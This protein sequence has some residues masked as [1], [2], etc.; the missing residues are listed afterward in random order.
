M[1]LLDLTDINASYG[2][3][4][5]L[6]GVDLTLSAGETLA[7]AGANG[8]GK[9]TLMRLLCGLMIPSRG[10]VRIDG[11][12][13]PHGNPRAAA[14]AGLALVPEGRL[15]FDSLTVEENLMIGAG[16]RQGR[17]SLSALYD[18]FPILR[19]KRQQSPGSL[20]GGQQQM[21]AIGRALAANPRILLC[22][23]ISLGLSP[24]VTG[25]VYN[26]LKLV[27]AEGIA[28]VVVDQ[29]VARA[30]AI[31]NRVACMFQGRV[32]L[33]RPAAAVDAASISAA[34]FGETA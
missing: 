16:A 15:L 29:D 10:A 17:W 33:D 3:M 30:Q 20:S 6:H 24:L 32:T 18:L 22:D 23:E 7:L 2:Q 25:E 8:A 5:A 9:T 21:V 1:P 11:R 34:F 4:A 13:L 26:A 19:D 14:A 28:L 31:S 27:Q 12:T